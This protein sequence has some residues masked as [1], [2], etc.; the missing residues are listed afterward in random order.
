MAKRRDWRKI[1][2]D[3][4]LPDGST[5]V[6]VKLSDS[7]IPPGHKLFG[8]RLEQ[9]AGLLKNAR[10]AHEDAVHRNELKKTRPLP[11][12]KRAFEKSVDRIVKR[13]VNQRKVRAA[14]SEVNVDS[15]HAIGCDEDNTAQAGTAET[16]S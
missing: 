10:K 15:I 6:R 1:K 16:S 8:R 11:F 12:G 7:R 4:V 13:P 5:V 14:L 9:L 2:W 3:E